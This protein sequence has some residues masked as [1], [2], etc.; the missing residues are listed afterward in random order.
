[1]DEFDLDPGYDKLTEA[2]IVT[3]VVAGEE[4]AMEIPMVK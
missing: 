2:D 4:E 3:S 1:M